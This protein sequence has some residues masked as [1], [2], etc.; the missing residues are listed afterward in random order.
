M[1]KDFKTCKAQDQRTFF[2]KSD[3]TLEDWGGDLKIRPK[4]RDECHS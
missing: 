4:R 2:G 3:N 1:R